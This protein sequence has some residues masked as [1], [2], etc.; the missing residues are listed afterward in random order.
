MK[1]PQTPADAPERSEADLD[2]F[3]PDPEVRYRLGCVSRTTV[4]RLRQTDPTFPRSIKVGGRS[5]TSARRLKS[6][7]DRQV[8]TSDDRNRS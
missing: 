3:L 2:H 6:W 5:V 8:D 1:R 7:M 4:W